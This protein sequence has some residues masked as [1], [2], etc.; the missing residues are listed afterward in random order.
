MTDL[1]IVC[2]LDPEDLAARRDSWLAALLAGA[3]ERQE[4]AE[5]FRWRFAP[6]S[7]RLAELA[8]MIDAER[9]CCRFL[10]FALTVEPAGG[11]FWLEV[12]GPEGTRSFLAELMA[13]SPG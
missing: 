6:S 3:D 1:P 8:R 11:P 2:E 7:G 4:L 5:G 10:R 9:S 13:G 12:T